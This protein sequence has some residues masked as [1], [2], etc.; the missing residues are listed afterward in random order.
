[1]SYATNVTAQRLQRSQ[2]RHAGVAATRAF[3]AATANFAVAAPE[4]PALDNFVTRVVERCGSAVVK[5]HT[6]REREAPD[7]DLEELL[8]SLFGGGGGE[9]FI[10]AD[11]I[12]FGGDG[13]GSN[14]TSERRRRER[15]RKRRNVL[16]GQGSGFLIDEH[17]VLTNAHVVKGASVVKV[18]LTT[19]QQ[20]LGQ[21]K[22]TDSVLDVAVVEVAAPPNLRLPS[23]PL[24]DG[25]KLKVGQWCISIGNPLGLNNSVSLGVLSSLRPST[26]TAL[27]WAPMDML[28]TDAA[29]N[30]GNSGGPLLNE[31]GEAI[32]LVH[33]KAGG[34]H[35]EG[36]GFAIPMRA[37]LPL[38]PNLCAGA[39]MQHAMLGLQ[40]CD[41]G[42][43]EA[44][45][46]VRDEYDLPPFDGTRGALVMNVLPSS[47]AAVADVQPGDVLTI[48]GGHRVSSARE[49]VQIV[50][51]F[52]LN[53]NALLELGILRRGGPM[54]T[55]VRPID[56]DEY[57]AARQQE[58]MQRSPSRRGIFLMP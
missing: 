52:R 34:M 18:L 1:M 31:R 42:I 38:I 16:R 33:A 37:L 28:Q 11:G 48:V 8:E 30:Q 7:G 55:K 58:R 9:M 17:H 35:T 36:L 51:G 53:S 5:I 50:S 4:A 29:I 46:M 41:N 32:G 49:V 54:G 43:S 39:T 12:L 13:G 14:S 22:G 23:I 44:A 20:L 45:E 15:R 2:Q 3:A 24:S 6:E 47:P 19:G 27:D 57:T 40:M 21:V 56:F 26:E 10:G 25:A